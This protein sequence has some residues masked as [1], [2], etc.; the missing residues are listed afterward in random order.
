MP[1]GSERYGI[2]PTVLSSYSTLDLALPLSHLRTDLPRGANAR[3]LRARQSLQAPEQR[4][5][6]GRLSTTVTLAYRT[7]RRAGSI[8]A[9]AMT[10]RR[11]RLHCCWCDRS[12][13]EVRKYHI[14]ATP[15]SISLPYPTLCPSGILRLRDELRPRQLHELLVYLRTE[16]VSLT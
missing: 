11:G 16:R 5:L 13:G 10:T 15:K 7:P 1:N 2:M 3:F 4:A 6:Y 9:R 8:C 12:R 14:N